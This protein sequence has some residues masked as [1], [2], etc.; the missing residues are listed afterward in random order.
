MSTYAIG[1]VQG[2][3]DQLLDLLDEI[4]YE[5]ETDVLWFAGDL[6][7]RG[8]KSLDV[9]RFVSSL[10]NTVV[11]LGNHDLHLLA[12][13]NEAEAEKHSD[14]F[15]DVLT[16]PDCEKLCLWLRKQ[17]LFHHDPTLAYSLLHAG[18]PPG[19]DI[20]Q[21]LEHASEVETVLQS[22]QFIEFLKHMYG[23]TPNEWNDNLTSWDR[24]R[25]IT[26]CFTR[27][28]FCDEKGRLDLAVKGKPGTQPKGF[29]PWYTVANRK[30]Q[31]DRILF[32]HW[33]SLEGETNESSVIAL[34]TG[35][36]WGRE[37]SALRLEDNTWFQVPG[38]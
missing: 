12:V 17:K 4:S 6:V 23:N 7:N 37:L 8:P 1:D 20:T 22:E 13:A 30:S 28:R 11:V 14:T 24:F 16:A 34:D 3:Y 15:Q 25:F 10:K 33:A 31:N 29:Q 18:L 5:P 2:C 38:L 26:N 9:L 36:V 21:A 35:C 32:G 19:W 27:I